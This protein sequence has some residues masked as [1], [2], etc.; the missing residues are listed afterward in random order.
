MQS[1]HGTL[2]VFLSA[3]CPSVEQWQ[4]DGRLREV[5]AYRVGFVGRPH[6]SEMRLWLWWLLARHVKFYL[7]HVD[8]THIGACD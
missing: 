4:R 6:V 5:G 1:L 8:V 3:A 7:I 2:A